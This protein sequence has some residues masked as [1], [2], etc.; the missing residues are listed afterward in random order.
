MRNNKEIDSECKKIVRENLFP[1]IKM[2][3]YTAKILPVHCKQMQEVVDSTEQFVLAMVN[4]FNEIVDKLY[5]ED[6]NPSNDSNLKEIHNKI[7][8]ILFSL[9]F[10]DSSRQIM[11]HVQNDLKTISAELLEANEI[12]KE[13]LGISDIDI[14]DID[15]YSSY[16]MSKER[17]NHKG[18]KTD[19]TEDQ[20]TFLD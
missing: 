13:H 15:C 17:N 2:S 12:A 5:S 20:I 11:E 7:D 14:S 16:T 3:I 1:L 18:I 19:E 10:Q 9:Q 4:N 8:D 6:S